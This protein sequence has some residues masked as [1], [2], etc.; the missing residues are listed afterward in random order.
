MWDVLPDVC[1]RR[2]AA[3]QEGI[4]ARAQLRLCGLTDKQ[5][6]KRKKQGG[7]VRMF[8]GV[9]R[10]GG[11]PD[12]FESRLFAVSLWLRDD[13]YFFGATA[14]FLLKLEGIRR[15]ERIS[16]ARHAYG[17]Y[18][19]WILV[20]RLD[21]DDRPPL[22]RARGHK[23]CCVERVLAECC[24]D[25]PPDQVGRALDDALRR[26]LTTLSRMDAF[27]DEWAGRK[28]V[29]VLRGLLSGRDDRDGKVRS[30]FESKMLSILRRI[31]ESTFLPDVEVSSD[32]E[33]YFLDFYCPEVRLGIECH[34]F[35]WHIG[36]HNEDARRDRR[37]RASGI[38]ILYFTW[39]DVSF[40]PRGVEREVRAALARRSTQLQLL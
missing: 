38:E 32:G 25:L 30:V 19:E 36:R 40:D 23:I 37:I 6:Q 12:S 10:L 13:G 27:L 29:R 21:P 7:L 2:I 35:K 5:I 26:R 16:V 1:V 20:H 4:V 34:S 8:R 22:R 14:A 18:P 31:H 15:P 24:G 9:Y 39:D 17:A 3:R 11:V 33:R 28:G